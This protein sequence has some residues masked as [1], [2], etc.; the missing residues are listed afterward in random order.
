MVLLE[1]KNELDPRGIDALS[2]SRSE[3][4]LKSESLYT[5]LDAIEP[6]VTECETD[7][8]VDQLLAIDNHPL[9]EWVT[10]NPSFD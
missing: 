4:A 6:A 8:V 2:M 1:L 7:M 9:I 10:P 3:L 5:D